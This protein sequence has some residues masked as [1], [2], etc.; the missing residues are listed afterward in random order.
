MTRKPSHTSHLPGPRGEIDPIGS[1]FPEVPPAVAA[2]WDA[3]R[4]YVLRRLGKGEAQPY[5]VTLLA[6]QRAVRHA[7]GRVI[8]YFACDGCLFG[9]GGF[10]YDP[11][12]EITPGWSPIRGDDPWSRP[13]SV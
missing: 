4:P 6:L 3:H 13:A 7:A 2:A 5:I 12:W 10:A 1:I 9:Y 8:G 11:K